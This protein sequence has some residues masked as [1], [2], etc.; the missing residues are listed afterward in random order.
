LSDEKTAGAQTPRLTGGEAV[1]ANELERYSRQIR[2]AEIGIEGQLQLLDSTV[3]L[4]GCGALGSVIAS[5]L[6]RSGVGTV[7]IAD[8]DF[9]ETSNLQRQFLFDE[10][11]VAAGLPKAVAAAKKLCQINSEVTIEPIVKDID[12]GN[13]E[14]F[15]ASVDLILDGTDNFETRFLINDVSAKQK[16]P[17][18]Y[19]GCLGA[20]GQSMS[21]LPGETACLHCLLTDG[22][23]PPGTSP[24]CDTAG[25]IAPIIGVIASIQCADA[26][27]ILSGNKDRVGNELTIVDLWENQFR[28]MNIGNLRESVECP[29]CDKKQF[30]WLTGEQG[31]HTAILCGRNAVQLSFPDRNKL[32]LAATAKKLAGS[33]D[34]Q[35]NDYLLRFT[36]NEFTLTLFP[37]GRA[38]VAGTEDIAKAKSIYSQFIGF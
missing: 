17:W 12:F 35:A 32:D 25:I 31:S 20:S 36:Q 11:D 3:L 29:V 34:V 27:K 23:P 21:I 5:T 26:I 14:S 4:I 33:G 38:I 15:C 18:V 1:F 8:R 37:D 10:T 24:T 6:V 13:I 16:I 22:P 30:R 28:R 9:L 19:G 2:F 7:K